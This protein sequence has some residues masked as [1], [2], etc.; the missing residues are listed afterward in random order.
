M[1]QSYPIHSNVLRSST[2]SILH[3]APNP[4]LLPTRVL[5]PTNLRWDSP[6]N[7]VDFKTRPLTN[8]TKAFQNP[9]LF[10]PKTKLA[11]SESLQMPNAYFLNQPLLPKPKLDA[12]HFCGLAPIH[13]NKYVIKEIPSFRPPVT[14]RR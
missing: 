3:R 2:G 14:I 11:R 8:H 1:P 7:V 10:S 5:R 12:R 13:E 4:Y 9:F 6:I